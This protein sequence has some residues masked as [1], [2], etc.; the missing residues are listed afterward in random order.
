MMSY[1]RVV[2]TF[3]KHGQSLFDSLQ[4]AIAQ[5]QPSENRKISAEMTMRNDIKTYDT[6]PIQTYITGFSM[7]VKT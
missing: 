6:I 1:L 3:G 7:Q 4:A 2:S 5:I